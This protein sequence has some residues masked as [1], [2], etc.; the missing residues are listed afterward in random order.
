[1]TPTNTSRQQHKVWTA[2]SVHIVPATSAQSAAT[3]AGA[4]GNGTFPLIFS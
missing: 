4:D 2:P 1:M 3:P